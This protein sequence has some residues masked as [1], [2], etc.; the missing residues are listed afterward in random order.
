M[1]GPVR[2]PGGHADEG[3]T[4]K[5]DLQGCDNA[6]HGG[7][8]FRFL[9][10]DHETTVHISLLGMGRRSI[11]FGNGF[12]DLRCRVA[13]AAALDHLDL[14]APAKSKE[15]ERVW[16]FVGTRQPTLR[17]FAPSQECYNRTTIWK[18]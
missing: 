7:G 8:S 12:T 6:E 14:Y 4:C 18:C 13:G 1:E 16:G 9:A 17:S 11:E 3:E 10:S 2:H 5:V 15:I